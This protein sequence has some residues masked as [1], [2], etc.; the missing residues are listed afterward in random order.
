MDSSYYF[1]ALVVVVFGGLSAFAASKLSEIG[2]TA[3]TS[4]APHGAPEAFTAFTSQILRI[5][6]VLAIVGTTLTIV[7]RH[8]ILSSA[9]TGILSGIAGYVLG[10]VERSPTTKKTKKTDHA[11]AAQVEAEKK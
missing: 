10:G 4:G 5:A 3:Y 9:V 11:P 2:K 8:E 1:W 7:L 6:A